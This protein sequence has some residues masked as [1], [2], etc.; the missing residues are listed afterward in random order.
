LFESTFKR[1]AQSYYD[2]GIYQP[3][4]LAAA[5]QFYGSEFLT[6]VTISGRNDRAEP[7]RPLVVN[8]KRRESG[9]LQLSGIPD[10]ESLTK[11]MCRPSGIRR[12]DG[13]EK[14][15]DKVS[16]FFSG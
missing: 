13:V 12:N 10:N 15:K 6:N 11:E 14:S 7:H 8:Y 16:R 5:V 2:I 4:A 9:G 1:L 3:S